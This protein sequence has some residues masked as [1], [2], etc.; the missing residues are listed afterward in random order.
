MTWRMRDRAAFQPDLAA[1]IAVYSPAKTKSHR[2]EM[3]FSTRLIRLPRFASSS[4]L[5]RACSQAGMRFY[6]S[7]NIAL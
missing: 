7:A 1:P 3:N 5:F 4:L 2:A 6:T